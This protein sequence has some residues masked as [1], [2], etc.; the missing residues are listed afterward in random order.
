MRRNQ[1]N[2]FENAGLNEFQKQTH[3]ILNHVETLATFDGLDNLLGRSGPGCDVPSAVAS[4]AIIFGRVSEVLSGVWEGSICAAGHGCESLD[5]RKLKPSGHSD[6]FGAYLALCLSGVG[7]RRS[8]SLSQITPV[9]NSNFIH[10]DFSSLCGS[11]AS[12]PGRSSHANTNDVILKIVLLFLGVVEIHKKILNSCLQQ[13]SIIMVV[14]L[15]ADEEMS[16]A[17]VD[18]SI[19]VGRGPYVFN[20]SGQIYHWI[21][22][23]CPPIGERPRFLQLY[24]YDTDNKVQN[25]MDHFGGIDNSQLEPRIVE[26]LIHFLDAHNELVQ[27]FRTARD[28]CRELEIPEFK[29]QL[30]YTEGARGYELPTINIVGAM[31]FENGVSDNAGYHT[32]LTLKSAN[33]VD[34]GKRV[35]ILAYYRYQLNFRLQQYDLLFRGG[36]PRYMYAHYLDALA[37]CQKLGNLQ[38]F[39][40]FTCNVSWPEIKRFI[41]EY[42]HLIASD[43][44]DVVCWVFEQKIQALIAFLK[45]KHIFGDVTGDSA[46]R[47]RIAEDVDQF[48]SAELPDPRIDPEGYNV[49]SEMM[50]HGPCE[51]AI[52]KA[53]CM[54]DDKC[55]KKFPKKFNQKTF[56]MKMVMCIIGEE[57]HVYLLQETNS[58]SIGE[59]STSATPSRQ[60]T[61]RDDD[62]LESVI[63]FPR[64]KST[65]LTDWKSWPPQKNNKSSI[66][67]LAYVHPTSGEL[68][69][70]R[71]LLC[72]QKGC[73]DFWEGYILYEIEIIL[74]NSGKSLHAFGLPSPPQDLLAQLANRLLMEERNYNWEELAQLKDES[75][76]LLKAE[77]RQMYDLIMNADTNSRQK[78]I[79]VYGHGG[80]GKT[81]L[82]KTIISSLRS[83][84]KIVLTIT[85]LA[86]MNHRLCFEALDRSVR[87]IVDRPSSLFD[88]KSVLLGGDFRQT[89]PVKKVQMR[90]AR[91]DISLEERSLVNSFTYWLLDVGDGKI[92]E[93]AEED[94]ENTLW[95]HVPPA[96]CLPPDEKD[97]INSKVLD[98]V[99]GESTIYMSQDEATPTGN[100][101]AEIKMLYPIENLNTFKLPGFP[102][103]QLELKVGAPVMLL[104]NVN[105]VG[106][107]CNG[108][109]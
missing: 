31:V 48:I 107:L 46:S 26:G 108:K 69:F 106:G 45:E 12:L 9:L 88:E 86:P 27:L 28:K 80:T 40:T 16:K 32:D 81:F 64:K 85:S 103:H 3:N 66:G 87:D 11:S 61:F 37:I 41:P 33:G 76:L 1:A 52:F 23:L 100:D 63:D 38:F 96:Y 49:V 10:A 2:K 104:R 75:V 91:P 50:M 67:R 44:A 74:S 98:M 30:Y 6:A 14:L 39:I 56:L 29:I 59:S 97:I 94:P 58:R 51:A 77:Q 36:S 109:G 78:L 15:H 19:N 13:V 89:L 70:L 62:R 105:I 65:T 92:G 73:R 84:G 47:I 35:T 18:E 25:K 43:R 82:W 34:K 53:S 60:I 72:H 22:S 71:M 24:I 17:K 7:S 90:V 20:V 8:R 55:S 57:T 42:P 4:L 83:E 54:K 5:K 68:F 95:V 102:P 101:G 93:P 99:V 79:F 21:G